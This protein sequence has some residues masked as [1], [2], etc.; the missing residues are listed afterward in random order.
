M[1]RIYWDSM[2]FIYWLEDHPVHAPRVKTLYEWME[3][4]GDTLCASAFS[5]SE[6]L[7]G[8]YQRNATT[9]IADIHQLFRP[10]EIE[11]IPFTVQTADRFARIRARHSVSPADAIHLASASEARANLFLTN[12]KRLSRLTVEGIDFIAGMDINLV[13]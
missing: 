1:S 5:V 10:P 9:L 13:P 4:R 8:P 6:V 11:L 12:D 3:Q 7:A 2:L